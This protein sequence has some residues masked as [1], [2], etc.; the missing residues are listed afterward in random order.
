MTEINLALTIYITSN[1]PTSLLVISTILRKLRKSFNHEVNKSF[2]STNENFIAHLS[3]VSSQLDRL[4]NSSQ[5]SSAS[6]SSLASD[7]SRLLDL[8]S[9]NQ[10]L[11]AIAKSDDAGMLSGAEHSARS[12]IAKTNLD[13]CKLPQP[14]SKTQ[15]ESSCDF[16]PGSKPLFQQP[17]AI[18][19]IAGTTL[20]TRG[21]L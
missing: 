5:M 9:S 7:V 10:A 20:M 19:S 17:V 6:I 3:P 13:P 8:V 12:V 18:V 16:L 11:C 15:V 1:M 21:G 4:E 14:P 2:A